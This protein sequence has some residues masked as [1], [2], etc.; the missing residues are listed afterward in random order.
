M[1][2]LNPLDMDFRGWLAA[3][4]S[5]ERLPDPIFPLHRFDPDAL[6]DSLLKMD[7][8]GRRPSQGGDFQV[9]WGDEEAGT[10]RA[11][12][13]SK[14]AV[15][16]ERG[17]RGLDGSMRW[18]CKMAKKINLDKYAGREA[19]VAKEIHKAVSKVFRET[20]DHAARV[21][22]EKVRGL[23]EKVARA[24]QE[25]RWHGHMKVPHARSIVQRASK[26]AWR[27]ILYPQETGPGLVLQRRGSQLRQVEV[28]VRSDHETG[29]VPASI[30]WVVI[31]NEGN[32]WKHLPGHAVEFAPTQPA[33]EVVEAVSSLIRWI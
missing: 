6:V 29:M 13:D 16:V 32:D 8:P 27:V 25:V 14:L 9:L 24:S 22:G 11:T 7:V 31:S 12:V 10:V 4:H 18:A 2:E 1:D 15:L 20:L 30:S 28:Q 17:V 3:P 19:S 23:A 33:A 26:H 5:D 21:G